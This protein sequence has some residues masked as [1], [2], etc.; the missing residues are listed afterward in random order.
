L[1]TL[2]LR[3]SDNFAALESNLESFVSSMESSIKS[4]KPQLID[5]LIICLKSL[6]AK[7]SVYTTFIA[8]GNCK[9]SAF[10][11]ECLTRITTNLQIA[12]DEKLHSEISIWLRVIV[13]LANASMIP[14]QSLF[15]LFH[16]LL[17]AMN[18]ETIA[19]PQ[20]RTDWF[21]FLLLS[22]IPW[23]G[24]DIANKHKDSLK[25]ILLEIQN[26]LN[27]RS[28]EINPIL[29]IFRDEVFLSFLASLPLLENLYRLIY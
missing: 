2:I 10:G 17:D 13:E 8:L 6:P 23:L 16:Q 28:K 9:S 26:Y 29:S 4:S 1:N 21:S 12:F 14:A 24:R 5:S 3:V 25:P 19:I 15:E 18:E 20:T 27:K 11:K 7:T 22:S